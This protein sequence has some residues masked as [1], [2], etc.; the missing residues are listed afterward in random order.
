MVNRIETIMGRRQHKRL[1]S[2]DKV[3]VV[4]R[5]RPR[6]DTPGGGWRYT[7]PEKKLRPQTVT[8][9]PFKRRMTE[10]LV[11]TEMGNVKDMPYVLIGPPGLDIQEGDLFE[12]KNENYEVKTID[13]MDRETRI[14]AQVDYYG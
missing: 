5:R 13:P 7:G 4:F 14:A 1:I 8:L 3:E 6:V 10:F 2:D 9:V 11:N 12:Y